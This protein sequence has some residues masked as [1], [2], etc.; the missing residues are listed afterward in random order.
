[1]LLD[2]TVL[3]DGVTPEEAREACRALK[4]SM[5]RQEVYALDGT[6]DAGRPYAVT[7]A[8]IR[9][10]CCSRGGPIA[11]RSS[12]P[13]PARRSHFHYE[14]KLRTIRSGAL[15]RRPARLATPSRSEL[16]DYGNVLS[17]VA[18]GYGRR[19]PD[20]RRCSPTLTGAKQ[21]EL[22][23]TLTEND[24]TNAVDEADAYRTPLPAEV[25]QLRVAAASRPAAALPGITN[26]FRFA[27]L[28]D[29]VQAAGDGRH[30]LPFEDENPTG[31]ARGQPYRR[32]I[33]QARTLYRPNDL[34]DGGGRSR[35]AAAVRPHSN[36][37]PCWANVFRLA[38]TPGCRRATGAAKRRCC[39]ARA[40]C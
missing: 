23:I 19:F 12:S 16:D 24:F 26:L 11:T 38:F 6:E 2:D 22:L 40:A 28:A 17:A 8:T 35:R 15:P 3:P 34:G 14:R 13:M 7:E 39:P 21:A 29:K 10:A 30:D 5:L 9:S 1:M 20:R 25:A 18:I 36:R 37:G 32:L 31:L 33:E 4:G 27:E